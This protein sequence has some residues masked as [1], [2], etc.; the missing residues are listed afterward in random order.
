MNEQTLSSAIVV[1][2]AHLLLGCSSESS[3]SCDVGA[4]AWEPKVGA[5]LRQE[6]D[7]AADDASVRVIF[8]VSDSDAAACV[9]DVVVNRG[10]EVIEILG[11]SGRSILARLTPAGVRSI[12][13]RADVQAVDPEFD[14]TPPP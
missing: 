13:S 10:G 11:L 6:L 3:D 2:V 8:T 1:M 7:S 5:A 12:A 9:N 4:G 14:N